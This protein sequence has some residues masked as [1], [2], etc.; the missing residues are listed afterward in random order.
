MALGHLPAPAPNPLP[1]F[2]RQR[3]PSTPFTHDT[4]LTLIYPEAGPAPSSLGENPFIPLNRGEV[5]SWKC[6]EHG[7]ASL[8]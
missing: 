6:R 4:E 3:S 2:E 5:A 7:A 1:H 8:D